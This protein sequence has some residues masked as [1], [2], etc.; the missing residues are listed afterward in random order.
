VLGL[1]ADGEPLIRFGDDRG[2]RE[3]LGELRDHL[4][5]SLGVR[6]LNAYGNA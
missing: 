2:N 4:R 3:F 5:V 1:L 6:D